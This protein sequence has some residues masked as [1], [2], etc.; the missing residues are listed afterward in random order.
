MILAGAPKFGIVLDPFIGSGTTAMVALENCRSC[1]GIE[2][3]AEYVKLA[4]ARLRGSR[5]ARLNL[6]LHK[7]GD[8]D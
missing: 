3:N 6:A 8:D 7:V 4:K 1:I 2:P 5:K